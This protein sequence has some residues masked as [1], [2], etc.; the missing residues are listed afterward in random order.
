VAKKRFVANQ[1]MK[2]EPNFMDAKT[3]V[4]S[5]LT[6]PYETAHLRSTEK[7][8]PS[9]NSGREAPNAG[10]KNEKQNQFSKGKNEHILSF[11]KDL[12]NEQPGR[13]GQ[14]KTNLAPLACPGTS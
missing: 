2:N 11:N 6:T 10:Q 14:N 9:S 4:T 3:N 5:G 8:N 12:R 7:T 13:P 1:K